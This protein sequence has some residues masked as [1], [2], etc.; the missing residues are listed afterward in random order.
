MRSSHRFSSTCLEARGRRSSFEPEASLRHAALVTTYDVASTARP[1]HSSEE[2][3]H[4]PRNFP[5]THA[6]WSTPRTIQ[7]LL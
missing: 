2:L 1:K 6:T 3:P 5:H 4:F 7:G